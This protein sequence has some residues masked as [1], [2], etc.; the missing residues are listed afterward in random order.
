MAEMSLS[1]GRMLRMNCATTSRMASPRVLKSVLMGWFA[2]LLLALVPASA[3]AQHPGGAAHAGGDIRGSVKSGTVPLP[4]VTVSA[5]NSLSGVKVIASTDISGQYLLHVPASGRYVV[6]AE[7]SG[8][9]VQTNEVRFPLAGIPSEATAKVDFELILESRAE[10]AEQ[11]QHQRQASNGNNS[12]Q[13]LSV[14][15]ASGDFSPSDTGSTGGESNPALPIPGLGDDTA[16]ESVSVSGA[17]SAAQNGDLSSASVQERI[18]E[19]RQQQ[20]GAA[21]AASGLYGRGG[22]GPFGGGGGRGF[23]INK[24]HGSAYYS[25]GDSAFDAAPYSLTGQTLAKPSFLQQNFGVSLGGP[26][27]IPKIYHG[28]TKTFF[29]LNYNGSHAS[30]PYTAFSTVPTEAER[31]GDFAGVVD[32]TGQPVVIYN[33]A[34]GLPFPGNTIPTPSISP[35]AKNLL[36][37]I[38][39][40]NLSGTLQ[41]FQFVE[42]PTTSSDALNLRLIHTFGNSTRGQ[43]RNGPHNNLNIGFRF[44]NSNTQLTNPYPTVGGHTAVLSF[45]VPIGYTRSFHGITNNLQFE[46][47]RNRISTQNLYTNVTNVAGNAGVGGVSTNPFDYGIPT[48]D[49]TNFGSVTDINPLLERDQTF[50]FSDSMIYVKGKH[51]LRWGGDFRRVQV[52][53][54]SDS[55]ARG[56][57]TFTGYN[58]SQVINGVQTPNTGFDFSDFLLGLPQLTS[59]Q[60]GD[61]NYHFRGNSWDLFVQDEWRVRSNLTFNL[62]LRYEYVS[63]FTETDDAIANLDHNPGFTAVA[64]VLPGQV[65]PYSGFFPATLVNPDRDAFAPRVGIA[66]KPRKNTVVRT[67][68]GINYTTT[69]Y[70][71]IAEQLAF[72][73]PFSVTSTNIESPTTPLMLANGFPP[74]T[75]G[76]ITNSYAVNKNYRL[77]YVQIWNLNIQQQIRPTLLVNVDY[78]GTKGTDLEVLEDPNRTAT[79]LLIPNAQPFNFQNSVGNSILHAGTLRVR[80]RLAGGISF[81]GSYTYSKSIDDASSIGGSTA[82]VA[83]NAQDLAAERGLSSFDQRQRLT[84]DWLWELPF[85][86][87]RRWL[88]E[89]GP[90]HSIFGNW[91]WSGDWTIASGMPFTVN[92]LGDSSEIDRGTNGTLRADTTSEPVAISNP[93]TSEWFNTAAFVV[94]AADTFGDVGRNTIIGPGSEVFDMAIT[95]VIHLGE[96]RLLEFRGSATNV[97]NHPVFTT[98]DTTVNSPAFGRVIAAGAMRAITFTARTRF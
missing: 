78:T 4:G 18:Q 6:R 49:F 5:T 61:N 67:G 27:N 47:N 1:L 92:V 22:G 65:G 98:I 59:V 71:N 97:F 91:Q 45:D 24:P 44:Q 34:T 76:T 20:G 16:T 81:G 25:V 32:N 88:R 29:F 35:V 57:F 31:S 70:Q 95:R 77:G 94:P 85:G 26:L 50:T 89:N 96:T 9:A 80:K 63:P 13:R 48:L 66:W 41:N 75:P 73:P 53:T 40:P 33:P 72:Q 10:N 3:F 60:F 86:T 64:P 46:F 30:N 8:F 36:A 68:Y 55:T 15:A 7:L 28:G 87:D 84:G 74:V 19:L 39:L 56:S 83:Q 38:P 52:N 54:E 58:T 90:L 43:G 93:T 2:G 23:D 37:Y 82:V 21:S 12:F 79:G 11:Q 69:A 42:A 62:G 17:S 51:R 14:T